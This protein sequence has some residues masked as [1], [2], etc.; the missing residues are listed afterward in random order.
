MILVSDFVFLHLLFH[1]NFLEFFGN[2]NENKHNSYILSLIKTSSNSPTHSFMN[3]REDIFQCYVIREEGELVS[4]RRWVDF[5]KKKKLCCK[6][7][8]DG[9]VVLAQTRKRK[10]K[11]NDKRRMDGHE[12]QNEKTHEV[13]VFRSKQH[14]KANK[15]THTFKTKRRRLA[16]TTTATSAWRLRSLQKKHRQAKTKT[17]T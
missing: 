1:K 17:T 13:S 3:K 4:K 10:L 8:C 9:F 11:S 12:I 15:R 5:Y 14:K 6:I 7:Y 16:L 2:N